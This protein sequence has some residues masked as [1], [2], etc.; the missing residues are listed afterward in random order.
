MNQTDLLFGGK[1]DVQSGKAAKDRSLS[2][3]RKA[4]NSIRSKYNQM[5][6]QVL[7]HQYVRSRKE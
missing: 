2:P 3:K 7:K 1:E 4:E 6:Q 5:M